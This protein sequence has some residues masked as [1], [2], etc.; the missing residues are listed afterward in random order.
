ML[1]LARCSLGCR[2]WEQE[3]GWEQQEQLWVELWVGWLA[4]W[5]REGSGARRRSKLIVN[6]PKK[7]INQSKKKLNSSM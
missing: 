3:Q 5:G 2:V 6:I 7:F 1:W 4:G